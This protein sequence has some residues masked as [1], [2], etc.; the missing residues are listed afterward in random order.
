MPG[1]DAADAFVDFDFVAV[2][3]LFPLTDL[4]HQRQVAGGQRV[5]RFLDHGFHQAA[6]LQEL[7]TDAFQIGVELL[8]CMLRHPGSLRG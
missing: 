8:V 4:L 7:R 3:F 1:Q 6:H 5:D 2:D